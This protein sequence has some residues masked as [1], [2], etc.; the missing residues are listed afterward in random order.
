MAVRL[1]FSPA[2]RIADTGKGGKELWPYG[3]ALVQPQES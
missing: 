1:G 2:E 3:W